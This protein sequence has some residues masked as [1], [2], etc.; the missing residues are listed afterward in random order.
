MGILQ[1][2]FE[3]LITMLRF[4][5]N[6]D[7]V[8]S[9]I[10]LATLDA[11]IYYGSFAVVVFVV[12]FYALTYVLLAIAF[13]KGYKNKGY[14][15]SWIC[16]V[17]IA[18][19]YCFIKLAD[20][21][22][23]L[24]MNKKLMTILFFTFTGIYVLGSAIFDIVYFKEVFS[25][26][27]GGTFD[28]ANHEYV[29]SQ[30]DT[31]GMCY[32]LLSMLEIASSVFFVGILLGFYRTRTNLSFLFTFLSIFFIDILG[33]FALIFVNKKAKPRIKIVYNPYGNPYG[34]PTN[35]ANQEPAKEP[36]GEFSKDKEDTVKEPFADFN[37]EPD[38]KETKDFASEFVL[39]EEKE[40][41]PQE[42]TKNENND[43]DDDLF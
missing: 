3:F 11:A 14:S 21:N 4:K 43:E 41:T 17:P 23:L 42:D 40:Q 26:W 5:E 13:K 35:N 18:Q 12:L 25:Y 8:T 29:L 30:S 15:G 2:V 19:L 22:K 34:T 6:P 7:I 39:P 24:G 32:V 9:D 33:I 20:T 31:Y 28:V 10:D 16:F 27:G 36:F 38:Y 37:K 1:A